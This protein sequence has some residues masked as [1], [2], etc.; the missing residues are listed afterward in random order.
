MNRRRDFRIREALVPLAVLVRQRVALWQ[1]LVRAISRRYRVSAF[2][3]LW[4]LIVPLVTL[5][6]YTFVFG[7]V[8]Q[9]RWDTG[10]T[11]L[12]FS[13]QLFAG[14]IVFWLMAD[15]MA[16]APT[17]IVEHANLVK[18]AVFPLEI[19]PAVVVGAALFHTL[20]NTA[21]LLAATALLA[22]VPATAVLFPLVLTPFVILLIGSAWILA[23]L[24]VYFRDMAHMMT[25]ILT[26]L[27]FLSPVFYP[28][29]RLSP[30]LQSIV[31]FNPVAF[32]VIQTRR[33]LL[34]GNMPDWTGLAIY[35]VAAWVIASLGF[36][37]FRKARRTFAD[38]L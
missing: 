18:K 1:F 17:C 27:L 2:G 25:L 38:V 5:G 11:E 7:S 9:S 20:I 14:L 13:L 3:F 37:F 19:I 33:V 24:G 31:V 36:I 4:V 12:P 30:A 35:L 22:H 26:G 10:T 16:Q 32:I 8:M 21:I 23:A 34:E 6:I 28:L 29:T 15:A